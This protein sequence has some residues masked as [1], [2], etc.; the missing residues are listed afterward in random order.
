MDAPPVAWRLEYRDYSGHRLGR[1]PP[2]RRCRQFKHREAALAELDKLCAVDC[3]E[4]VG[5][6]APIPPKLAAVQDD[7]GFPAAGPRRMT[8]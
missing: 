7:F 8:P 5:A 2:L 6:V 4:I 3:A 1:S